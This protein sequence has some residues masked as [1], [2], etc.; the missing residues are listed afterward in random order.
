MVNKES[1]GASS[2]VRVARATAQRGSVGLNA[3]VSSRM[4][5]QVR[6][7]KRVKLSISKKSRC[8]KRKDSV[9]NGSIAFD[10]TKNLGY[11]A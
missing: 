5:V 7:A 2:T 3:R 1:D 8:S 9:G 6:T 4:V 11:R 10:K